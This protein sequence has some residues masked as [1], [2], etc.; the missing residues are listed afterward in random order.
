VESQN[1]CSYTSVAT[2]RIRSSQNNCVKLCATVCVLSRLDSDK[3]LLRW[4]LC[5]MFV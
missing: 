5:E 2:D 1:Q 3:N 4:L